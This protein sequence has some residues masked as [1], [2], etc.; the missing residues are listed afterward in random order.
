MNDVRVKETKKKAECHKK[1]DK[2]SKAKKI[3]LESPEEA[4]LCKAAYTCTTNNSL[5]R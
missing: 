2:N 3:A 1:T 4:L 5:L